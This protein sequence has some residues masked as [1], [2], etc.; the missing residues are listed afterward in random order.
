MCLHVCCTHITWASQCLKSL[1]T[2][3]LFNSLFKL[4]TKKTPKIYFA[5]SLLALC[6]GK[7]MDSPHK[8]PVM[9]KAFPCQD[10]MCVTLLSISFFLFLYLSL[11]HFLSLSPWDKIYLAWV[12]D[13][14]QIS[15]ISTPNIKIWMF[16]VSSCSCLCPIHWTQWPLLLRKLTRD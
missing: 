8:G 4:T 15:N 1:A 12:P 7:P 16:L 6:E 9:K 13:Y 11:F 14:C 2:H 5:G 10:I 3:L